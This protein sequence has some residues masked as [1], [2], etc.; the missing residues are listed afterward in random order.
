MYILWNSTDFSDSN[1]LHKKKLGIETIAYNENKILIGF[2]LHHVN[3]IVWWP[4]Q[5]FQDYVRKSDKPPF[6]AEK[7]EGY[8]RHLVVRMTSNNELMVVVVAHPQSLT[9][10]EL[11]RLKNDLKDYFV[12]GAGKACNISSLYFQQ[13]TEK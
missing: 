4:V 10:D 1:I 6:A 8:W 13:F 12:K 9:E 7:G 2:K 3:L 5:L 11:M